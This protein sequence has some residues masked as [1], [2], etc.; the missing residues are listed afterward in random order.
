MHS[1]HQYLHSKCPLAFRPFFEVESTN[2]IAWLHA[3]GFVPDVMDV[4]LL[5]EIIK[6]VRM[7]WIV[8][9][10]CLKEQSA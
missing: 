6:V 2:I 7:S 9:C 1:A 8:H 5:D 3:T 10:H 4:S